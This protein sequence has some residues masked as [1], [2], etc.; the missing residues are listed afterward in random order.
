MVRFRHPTLLNRGLTEEELGDMRLHGRTGR[1]LG[2]STFVERLE[3]I[4][5]RALTPKKPGRKRKL[6][7]QPK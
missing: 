4:V 3:R 6:P 7:K 1:P 2:S 5:G